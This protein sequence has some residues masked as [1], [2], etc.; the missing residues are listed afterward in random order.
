MYKTTIYKI[1]GLHIAL[2]TPQMQLIVLASWDQ[3]I[4]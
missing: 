3:L 4:I 1:L 2:E